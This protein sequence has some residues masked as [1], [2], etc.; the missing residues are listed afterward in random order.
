MDSSFGRC[1]AEIVKEATPSDAAGPTSSPG[2]TEHLTDR[3]AG[4]G[5]PA[6]NQFYTG[7]IASAYAPLRG[8]VAPS[9]PY[10]RFVRRYGEPGLEIGC[11]HGEPLLDLIAA[12]L[13][14]VGVD[15]S[16]DMVALCEAAAKTR[17][18]KVTVI[19]S[20]V[21][22]M[23]LKK[24]FRSIYFAGPTFQL[25]ID[26]GT[27]Q[28][29][30]RQM[31]AH[32]AP[33]GRI[34]VPLFTPSPADPKSFGTWR[35]HVEAHGEVVAFTTVSQSYRVNERRVDTILRYRRGA[36]S[37][38]SESV[39]RTWSL[40]WYTDGEFEAM[41]EGAGLTV[42]HIVDHAGFGRSIVLRLSQPIA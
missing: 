23:V 38:P 21:E 37:S 41:A 16:A 19:C 31:A 34:L 26:D 10:E 29:A 9:E 6:P 36:A 11:G 35:E 28:A 7:L 8:N 2:K 27:P 30:L 42:D 3:Q 1:E 20:R 15:S 17:G 13:E 18:V 40:R 39:E 25:L 24:S 22:A 14:V 32:L 4:S 33:E 12:G 5:E